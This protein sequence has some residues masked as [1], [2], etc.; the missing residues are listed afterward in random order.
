MGKGGGDVEVIATTKLLDVPRGPFLM[1]STF[2][3]VKGKLL[4]KKIGRL[5]F[6]SN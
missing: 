3:K 4:K 1:G 2:E 6:S 5:W